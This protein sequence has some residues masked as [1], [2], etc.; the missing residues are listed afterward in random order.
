MAINL[1]SLFSG[2]RN[3][4]QALEQAIDGVIAID[5]N[6]RITFFNDAAE[7]LWGYSRREVMGKNVSMLVPSEIRSNHDQ[8]VNRNR[9]TGKDVIV[10]T[11]RDVEIECKDGSR[12]WCN[13]SLSKVDMGDAI[14][15]TAFVKNVTEDVKRRKQFETLSLVA[16]ETDNSVIITNS[17]CNIE[18]VNPGFSRLTGYTFE[19]VKGKKPGDVLQGQYTSQDT[20]R[21]FTTSL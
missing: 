3:A 8:L 17:E 9:T 2:N 6:N 5:K 4:I 7:K 14:I 11:S 16:N 15:Y 10:G 1:L 18:Y 20:K 21:R 12:T 19:E 13:L